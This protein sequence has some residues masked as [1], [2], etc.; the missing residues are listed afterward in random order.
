MLDAN[1]GQGPNG[2]P[3]YRV[4]WA[5]PDGRRTDYIIDARTGAVLQGY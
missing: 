4:V 3:V 2:E 1:L 5:S